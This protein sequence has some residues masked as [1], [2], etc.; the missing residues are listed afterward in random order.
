MLFD[1]AAL[2]ITSAALG[3]A[4]EASVAPVNVSISLPVV[5]SVPVIPA[6]DSNAGILVDPAA[7]NHGQPVSSVL[8]ADPTP[9]QV[10]TLSGISL[11]RE[12]AGLSSGQTRKLIASDPQLVTKLLQ[13][14]PTAKEVSTLWTS[15]GSSAR[16][17]LEKAAPR[18]VGGLDGFPVDIRNAANRDWVKQSIAAL[19]RTLPSED[20]RV[21][22][23]SDQHELHML[24]MVQAALK[25]TKG[26]PARSLLSADTDGQ[27]KAV[28]VLGNLQSADYVTYLVPGMFYTVDGQLS[29]WTGDAADLYTQQ[30]AWLKRLSAT[31]PSAAHK[32]VAVVA[33]M[34]YQTPDLTNIG[35][36]DL[37]NQARDALSSSVE[38][39]QLQRAGNLPYT[40]IVA[41]S[42]GSTAAL[43]ALTQYNFSVNALVLVGTPGSAA[44]SAKDLHVDKTNV[45]VGSAAWDPV[46][47]SAFFGSDP[48]SPSYGAHTM[49]VGGGTDVITGAKLG[50]S[51]GHN[52]YFDPG[53][54]S[55]RNMALIG[56]G[57]PELVMQG[58]AAD[59]TRTLASA[60]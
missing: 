55:V 51:L 21:L 37:A 41:H 54:E 58:D 15:L 34:G 60:K 17:N 10:R 29:A 24:T 13:S 16:T 12:L 26:G 9:A 7:L 4:A 28:I 8:L 23:E 19:N 18:L 22:A 31:D 50:Q 57:H 45:W 20:G 14:P 30:T 48:S 3:P 33:W 56:I 52:E 47:T 6:V 49:G 36:L 43:M 2:L 59:A 11:V 38:S 46:P 32:T 27:G 44:Q 5:P 42:Y 35:S 1:V 39:L 25:P 53:T 40:T